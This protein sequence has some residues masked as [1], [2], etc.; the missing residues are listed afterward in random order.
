MT[1]TPSR[2]KGGK[3]ATAKKSARL[4]EYKSKRDFSKTPEPIARKVARRGKTLQFVV[5]KHD[6]R[7][8][9]FDLRLELDG[10]LK[11]WAVTRGPSMKPGVRRLAVQTEDHPMAY[12]DWEGEIPKGEYGGGTMIVWDRGTWTPEGDPRE[13][14]NNGKLSFL[15]DGERLK[16]AFTLVR[17]KDEGKRKNWLLI[18]RTDEH[19]MAEEGAEPVEQIM[20]SAVSGRTNADIAAAKA[21][22]PDHKARTAKAETIRPT[23]LLKLPG[24]RKGILPAFVEPSLAVSAAEP[25]KSGNWLH[26]I[27]HDGYRIQ[28][29]LDG[30]KVK[31]LTRK[32]L[33]WSKRFPTIK[34]SL[35]ALKVKSALLDGEIIVQ[36]ESGHSSFSGLQAALKSSS[37]DRMAF[38]V[39]DLLHLNGIDLRGVSLDGRKA[40]L[41]KLLTSVSQEFSLR[42]IDHL[43]EKEGDI[44]S[45]ACRLGLEGIISKR[46]DL[47]YVSGRGEHWVKSKCMLRQEFVIVGYLPASDRK[48]AIGSL[49]LAYYNDGKLHYAGRAGT[50]YSD[51]VAAS[52]FQ[53]LSPL[54]SEVPKFS[55]AITRS[56]TKDVVWVKPELVA[57]VE[58]RGRTADGLLRQAAYA[59]LREDKPAVEVVLEQKQNFIPQHGKRPDQADQVSFKFTSPDRKLW[60]DVGITKQALGNFYSN[61]A[62]WIMPHIEGR[63]LSLVRCPD[64][65][66]EKCFFAKHAWMGLDKSIHLVDV[67]DEKAMMMVKDIR[68]VLALVQMSVLEIHVW[69]SVNTHIETPDRL[70]FDLDPGE[71][72]DWDDIRNAAVELKERLDAMKLKSFVKTS[73]GKGLHVVVPV[74]PIADWSIAKAFCKAVAQQMALDSPSRYVASMAK[75]RRKGRIFID[76]LRNSRGAT[77]IAPYSTRARAGATVAVPID[78]SELPAIESSG[79]FTVLTLENRLT[80][81]ADD[82]W[83]DIGR[84]RQK[85][86]L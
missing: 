2:A 7:R 84:L 44:L 27:K 76:Y 62:C 37:F 58:Y 30:G 53:M 49:V 4:S 69:G 24:S 9:H 1:P 34:K 16:G 20:S 12:K 18:K 23:D 75:N 65:V 78:W 81:L 61:I 32:G 40:V 22:R 17:M 71:G 82:P 36:N 41:S 48:N 55:N 28:A 43:E 77:A 66:S 42:Y 64:G 11:S 31:L 13:G 70:I 86:P 45:H 26:E 79:Q 52:L 33:D 21:L 35:E 39:F 14:L 29:R 15:L 50:G 38:Y 73:G 67:G 56:S 10:V 74:E 3:S 63:V 57:E 85:L 5:Q 19:A 51:E 83:K 80:N 68:G 60:E 6:A 54:K 72:I 47:P 59:G 46:A 25:P 8:L